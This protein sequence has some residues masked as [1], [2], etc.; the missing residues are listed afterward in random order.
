MNRTELQYR[1][2]SYLH[3]RE[4]LGFPV[5]ASSKV[6][7]S[8]VDFAS[9][10]ETNAAC[11]TK[12][13]FDWLD[14]TTQGRVS[15]ASYRLS[16]VRQFLFHLSAALP[17]TQI[18]EVRLISSRRRPTPF[19]FSSEEIELLLKGAAEIAP[20][21]FFSVVL[22]T[23]L[24]L[25]SAAGLRASEALGLERQDIVLQDGM[26][27]LLIRESKFKKSRMVPLHSS[28]TQQLVAYADHRDRLGA[29]LQTTAF[30]VSR[31]GQR[32][33]YGTLHQ[34]FRNIVDQAGIKA[35]AD[36]K[37]P[38]LHSLR[39]SFVVA[40]LRSWHEQGVDVQSR[41]AHLAAYLG[42]VDVRESYWYMTATPELLR[43]AAAGFRAPDCTGGE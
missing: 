32:L 19:V 12:L 38:T 9:A 17:D 16:L 36:G 23:V 14:T 35:R 10:Q 13:V 30:F 27:T 8:F 3:I 40:R 42:H 21:T 25:I 24:G 2:T 43:A 41:L 28:T 4:A 18:P 26:G 37:K 31:R 6:L 5:G 39:H 15:R 29:K 1:L 20:G 34:S 7:D 33:S 11:T 22:Q